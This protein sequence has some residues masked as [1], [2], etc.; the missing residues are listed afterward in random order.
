MQSIV[1][2]L[3][4]APLSVLL[5]LATAGCEEERPVSQAVEASYV[6]IAVIGDVSADGQP[7][8]RGQVLSGGTRLVVGARSFC[9]LQLRQPRGVTIRVNQNSEFVLEAR[10]NQQATTYQSRID[11]GSAVFASE[12]LAADEQL[13]VRTPTLVA[14]VRGTQFGVNVGQDQS[15]RVTVA[16]GAVATRPSLG[17]AE[18]LPPEVV[19]SSEVLSNAITSLERSETTVSAGQELSFTAAERDQTLSEAGLDEALAIPEISEAGEAPATPEE[20]R[21]RAARIDEQLRTRVAAENL[22]RLEQSQVQPAPADPGELQRVQ[23]EV[24]QLTPVPPEELESV[25]GQPDQLRAILSERAET[26]RAA[27]QQKIEEL[28]GQSSEGLELRDGRIIRGVVF[29]RGA[30]YVVV[31]ADGAV[32][33]PA[34]QVLGVTF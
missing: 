6:A 7:V 2:F 4:P 32:T 14:A 30:D 13:T 34:S 12:Q 31:N 1:K 16:D 20:A 19:E 21:E 23:A 18:E 26:N 11:R 25:V 17:R 9:D 28:Y 10:Q 29:Q 15:T 22:Q 3:I 8:E 24:Q 27:V 33:I 5:L